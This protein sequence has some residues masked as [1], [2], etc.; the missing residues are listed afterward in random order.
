MY[1]FY[2]DETNLDPNVADFFV[3]GG[4]TIP[5]ER[6]RDLSYAI[7][8]LR[9]AHGLPPEAILKFNPAPGGLSHDQFKA[10]KQSV[11]EAAI[12]FGC[13]FITTLTLHRIAKHPDEARRFAINSTVHHY[14]SF[15]YRMKSH[16]MVLIDRFTDAQLDEQLR[17]RFAVGLRDMPFSK[18]MRLKNIV[19]FHYAAIGQAHFGSLIDIVLG[20]FRFSINAFTKNDAGRRPSADAILKLLSPLFVR[21]ADG[22]VAEISLHFSPL[23]VRADPLRTQYDALRTY[24]GDC[25]IEAVQSIR[26]R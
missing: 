8:E 13:Q 26:G 3:Y 21:D 18:T 5:A 9:A 15:L 24:L 17:D 1:L 6:A 10:L 12:H 20:S 23:V 25:G 22:R 2:T 16:G 4:L 7:D 19:G 14:D 11:V